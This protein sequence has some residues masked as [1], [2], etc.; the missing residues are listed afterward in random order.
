VNLLLDTH[1][2]LWWRLNSRRINDNARG[3]IESADQVF[4]SA[5]SAWEVAIKTGVGSLR[6]KDPFARLVEQ[7]GFVPLPISFAHAERLATLPRH[8]TDPFDRMIVAQAQDEQ[9]TLVTHDRSLEPYA[10]SFVWT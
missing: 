5:A 10:I 9:L 8:H 4:V 6:L 2:V 3:A 7:S 1:V